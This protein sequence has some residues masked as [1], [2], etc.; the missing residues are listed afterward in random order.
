LELARTE[1][2]NLD[3]AL[4]WT[5]QNDPA[6]G[7]RIAVG[8]GWTWVVL[9]DGVA[10]ATRVR[11]ALEAADDVVPVR[12]KLAGRLVAGWLEAS[13]GNVE[14]AEADLMTAL[15]A[16]RS[17]GDE[18][19]AADVHRHLAFLRIQQGRPHD[20]ARGAAEALAVA[21]RLGLT[22]ETGGTLLLAAYAA[23][24]L[25]DL[26]A[27]RRAADEAVA[28][29]TPLDD[30]WAL[31]HAEAMLGTIALAAQRFPEAA[32]SL[33]RAAEESERLGFVGQAALHLTRL[34]RTQQRSGDVAASVGTLERAIAAA[35]SAGDMRMAATARL[36]SARAL[37]R[38]GDDAG[39]LAL[40]IAADDWFTGAG[41][42]EDALV[43]RCLRLSASRVD[44][45]NPEPALGELLRQARA[46]DDAEAEVL[47]L[48]ALAR[49]RALN[50]DVDGATRLLGTADDRSTAA[51]HA[52]DDADRVDAAEARRLLAVPT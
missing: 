14:R 27:A 25:G 20:A 52:L 17:I 7:V 45:D 33:A 50:G 10:A 12:E 21:R 24:M 29:M 32:A 43:T 19:L 5:A 1:R 30:A 2:A 36:H 4:A 42:G 28:L 35:T 39:A 9:G 49:L 11:G 22:W 3:A 15:A 40:L 41:G 8:L 26:E 38:L 23:I 31:V 47:V 13:A 44:G 16:A 34:G 48:D 51:Q 6:L 46:A 37:R 18:S